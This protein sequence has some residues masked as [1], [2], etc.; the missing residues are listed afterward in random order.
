MS[1]KISLVKMAINWTPKM[2]VMWVANIILKGIAELSDYS[3]D[4]D[5][6]KV[7]VQTTLYGEIDP[8]EVWLDGFAI[9]SEEKSKYLILEQGTSNKPWLTN[10]FSKIAG[11]PWKIPAMPQFA[12]HIDF[13]AEL[14]KAENAPEQLD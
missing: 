6:R 11:K 9:I 7:Y 8:I 3:F 12:A 1:F 4:L 5:A 14:L 10:I 13:I 2:M